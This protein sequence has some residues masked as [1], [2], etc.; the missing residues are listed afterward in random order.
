ME[1]D[2]KEAGQIKMLSV[3]T[4]NENTN[5]SEKAAVYKY[6][7]NYRSSSSQTPGKQENTLENFTAN[8]PTDDFSVETC[9]ERQGNSRELWR[10]KCHDALCNT[11]VY[12]HNV[13]GLS[14]QL[15]D[16]LWQLS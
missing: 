14:T 10:G 12:M 8:S 11:V 7:F 13:T 5:S 9:N 4:D 1:R 6:I 16:I 3:F 2:K 15:P